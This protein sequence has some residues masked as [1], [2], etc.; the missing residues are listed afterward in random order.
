MV[1]IEL[2]THIHKMVE[3]I[4]SEQLLQT[5]YDFLRLREKNEPGQLWDSLTRAQ[6]Q[7]VLLSFEE[8]E[9]ETNLIDRKKVF[10]GTE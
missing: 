9:D 6:K 10:K 1:V 4:Q 5:L 7:D 3:E 2:K 8:S